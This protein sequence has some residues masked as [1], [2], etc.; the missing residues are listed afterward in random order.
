M[1]SFQVLTGAL[2]GVALM[3]PAGLK[4]QDETR[5]TTTTTTTTE[6]Q[7]VYDPAEKDYH[8]WNEAE[9]RAYRMYLEENHRHY[10]EFPKSKEKERKEYF[11]WR[12]G[13]PDSVIIKEKK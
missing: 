4:A 5:K 6:T 12:H 9:D 13:H 7:R 11:K 1:K 2:L 3:A 8:E 10:V